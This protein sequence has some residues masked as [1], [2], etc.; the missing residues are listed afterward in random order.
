MG[1]APFQMPVEVVGT[2][3]NVHEGG[4]DLLALQAGV[5]CEGLGVKVVLHDPTMFTEAR[6]AALVHQNI[7]ISH[8]VG[9]NTAKWWYSPHKWQNLSRE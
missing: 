7:T 4:I 6:T 5:A 9:E 1:A 8:S 2:I 3:A